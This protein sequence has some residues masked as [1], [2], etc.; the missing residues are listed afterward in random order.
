M[1]SQFGDDTNQAKIPS[2]KPYLIRALHQWCIDNSYTPYVSVFV[3]RMVDVPREYVKND[4]IVNLANKIKTELSNNEYSSIK[5]E[6]KMMN[7]LFRNNFKQLPMIYWYGI[8]QN[9]TCLVMSYYE[10]SLEMFVK[11]LKTKNYKV[12]NEQKKR[13]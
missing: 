8:H 11:S 12:I 5:H 13:F 6:V 2:T 10:C 3:D 4:E 9:L 1:S 7:Y